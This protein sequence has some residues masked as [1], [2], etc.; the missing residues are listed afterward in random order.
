MA[1]LVRPPFPRTFGTSSRA[2]HRPTR[3][4][5]SW[6]GTVL[7]CA[8]ERQTP[9][10]LGRRAPTRTPDSGEPPCRFGPGRPHSFQNRHRHRPDRGG[11]GL[12][13]VPIG[14]VRGRGPLPDLRRA[15][16]SVRG[17]RPSPGGPGRPPNVRRPGRAGGHPGSPGRTGRGGR[18]VSAGRG[19]LPAP[20]EPVP[21]G[22]GPGRRWFRG[23]PPRPGQ[24]VLGSFTPSSSIRRTSLVS[25]GAPRSRGDGA[26]AER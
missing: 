4:A 2:V 7:P 18:G 11:P 17:R 1:W 26:E 8:I 23:A 12:P 25:F 3:G 9:G 10:G 5:T 15:R 13:R 6:P 14:R 22:G 21:L 19:A 24:T 20:Q 16:G